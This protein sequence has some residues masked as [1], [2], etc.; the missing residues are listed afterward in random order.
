MQQKTPKA[1]VSQLDTQ[2]I[3]TVSDNSSSSTFRDDFFSQP[4]EDEPED[5]FFS[6]SPSDRLGSF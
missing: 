1:A 4:D 6:S 3:A 5:C 2:V